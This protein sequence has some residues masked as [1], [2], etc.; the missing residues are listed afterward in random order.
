M[1]ATVRALS[2]A[3][4]DGT[5]RESVYDGDLLVFKDI[6]PLREFCAFTDALIREVFE[7]D[8]LVAQFE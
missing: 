1:T 4:E 2:G 7:T 6:P 5:R 8:P 3:L